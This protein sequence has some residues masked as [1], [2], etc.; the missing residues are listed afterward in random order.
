MFK[1]WNRY[2][3][4]Y[5]LFCLAVLLVS[6]IFY[7]SSIVSLTAAILGISAV[8][9][10]MKAEKI[11]F[12]LYLLQCIVYSYIA[13]H[14]KFYGEVVRNIIYSIPIYTWSIIQWIK[15]IEKRKNEQIFT[16]SHRFN[17]LLV[18]FIVLG[19]LGYGYVLNLLNSS[20]PYLNSLSTL[21]IIVSTF[22]AAKSIKQQWYYWCLYCI[23]M[24][25]LW[26]STGTT[27]FPLLIQNVLFLVLNI[28]GIITWQ[29]LGTEKGLTLYY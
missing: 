19:T 28:Q 7:H 21:V 11:C 14:E 5:Y 24:F 18:V 1:N 26:S 29:K 9:M 6:S 22:L 27:Q 8:M 4:G 10:N 16:I 23:V 20:Q 15:T 13:Y 2:D 3:Y 12:V 17:S 25:I